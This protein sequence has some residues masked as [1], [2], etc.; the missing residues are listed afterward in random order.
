MK[1]II[2]PILIILLMISIYKD[3]TL[4]TTISNLDHDTVEHAKQT[5][6]TQDFHAIKVKIEQGDTFISVME[7]LNPNL[8]KINMEQLVDDFSYLNPTEDPDHLQLHHYYFFPQ[9]NN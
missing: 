4:G 8:E 1:K 2:F 7:Q 5:E 9:Y 6:I 3:L